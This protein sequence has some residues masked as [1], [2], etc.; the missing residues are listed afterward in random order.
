MDPGATRPT[1]ALPEV[2]AFG[3][4]LP[5]WLPTDSHA[6]LETTSVLTQIPMLRT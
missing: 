3:G 5:L 1:R 6:L 4:D 2:V